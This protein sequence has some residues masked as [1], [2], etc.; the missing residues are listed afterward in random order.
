MTFQMYANNA[1][2]SLASGITNVQTTITLNDA[3]EFAA[4][5]AGEQYYVTVTEGSNLEIMLVTDDA[6]TPTLTVTRGQQG[7][8]GVAFNSGATVRQNV[9][10][11]DLD[12]F[13]QRADTGNVDLSS[14]NY[15]I[16]P[17]GS[18]P[19]VDVSGKIALDTDG[20]GSS[21]T[22]GVIKAH[23]GTQNIYFFAADAYPS[24]DGDFLEYDSTN[25]KLIWRDALIR[26]AFAATATSQSVSSGVFT[27]VQFDTETFD[28]EGDFDATTNYRFTPSIAGDY[29][30]LSTLTID[31]LPDEKVFGLAVYKN[32]AS[33]AY[34]QTCASDSAGNQD[35][36]V[37]VS[38]TV[39]MNGSSDYIEI[40]CIQ[41]SGSS[42][43]T[44]TGLGSNFS[45]K[46]IN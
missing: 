5:G 28:T 31:D 14:A 15:L 41:N 1:I 40:F 22:Q 18:N 36:G 42:K 21:V 2:D 29:E 11:G 38:A 9:T 37:T 46:R 19:T 45:A 43:N 16:L 39:S 7:T 3:T 35:N 12:N 8:S 34:V 10:K 33:V 6:S 23:D 4:I 25:N 32:G 27:K 13:I 17:Y 20:D 26:A 30:I 24:S 44:N